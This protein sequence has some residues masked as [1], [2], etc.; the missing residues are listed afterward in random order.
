MRFPPPPQKKRLK[1]YLATNFNNT[2]IACH[3]ILERLSIFGCGE[4]KKVKIK[5]CLAFK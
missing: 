4:R 1:A 3:F 5:K 2:K